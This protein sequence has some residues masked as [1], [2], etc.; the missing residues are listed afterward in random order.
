MNTFKNIALATAAVL[1][2]APAF[3][4]VVQANIQYDLKA[5]VNN[6]TH[7]FN[8][9]RSDLDAPVTIGDGDSVTLNVSFKP[10]QALQWS[11][12]GYLNAWLGS[13]SVGSFTL[14]NTRLNFLGLSEG[15]QLSTVF[16][17]T[18]SCCA[19]TGPSNT[20]AGDGFERTFTGF[21][22]SYDV[23]YA[24][25][26]SYTFNWVG[27]LPVFEYGTVTEVDVAQVPEP[28]SLSLL[29]LGIAGLA[30]AR[31]RRKAGN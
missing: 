29:G 1:L 24:R 19:H 20:V 30:A 27:Y 11:G 18:S 5:V 17:D 12:N 26:G 14:S 4:G 3:A 9:T 23:D 22:L 25:G 10:G 7:S 31:R 16:P 6:T 28:A 8:A 21:Q 13:A 2:S 15:T